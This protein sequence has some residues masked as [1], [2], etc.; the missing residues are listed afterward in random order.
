MSVYIAL[1]LTKRPTLDFT[2]VKKADVTQAINVD[3]TVEAAQD[4]SLSFEQGGTVS[5]VF[6]QDGD[7]VTYGLEAGA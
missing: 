3:G 6:V 1:L 5:Q 4:L 2:S 7:L